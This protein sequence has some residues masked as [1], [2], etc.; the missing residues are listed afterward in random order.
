MNARRMEV[1]IAAEH[2]RAM[3]DALSHTSTRRR[4][5]PNTYRGY[6]AGRS[7]RLAAVLADQDSLSD[8]PRTHFKP[9]TSSSDNRGGLTSHVYLRFAEIVSRRRRLSLWKAQSRARKFPCV[10]KIWTGLVV[11]KAY[12]CTRGVLAVANHPGHFA[13]RCASERRD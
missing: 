2:R 5:R 6:G 8:W 4:Q 7:H 11:K 13:Q 1:N 3:I 10:R 12:R 9:A